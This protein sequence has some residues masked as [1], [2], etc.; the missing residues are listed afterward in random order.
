MSQKKKESKKTSSENLEKSISYE[1]SNK[2]EDKA[3]E[4]INFKD[5]F[6]QDTE[7]VY[8]TI[9]LSFCL[10][11]IIGFWG[12]S[13]YTIP[14]QIL[15]QRDPDVAEMKEAKEKEA[16]EK[17]KKDFDQKISDENKILK[18]DQTKNWNIN[19]EIK[20]FG[21]LTLNLNDKDAPK[22]VENFV[23]LSHR[24][25]YDNTIFHRIVKTP[26]FYIIQGGDK[27]SSN[28]KGGE[29]A[30]YLNN[31]ERGEIE[32]E[33]WLTKPEFGQSPNGEAIISNK[34]E[35]RNPSFYKNFNIQN[36]TVEYSKGLVLMAKKP[37]LNADSQFFITLDKTIL[38]AQ[39]T[40]FAQVNQDSFGTL[41]KIKNQINPKSGV[42]GIPDKEILIEKAQ[43]LNLK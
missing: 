14:Y 10:L 11:A 39:Y 30:F 32:D 18:F 12:F 5:S 16:K 35:F 28:G 22:T 25:Y 41:D 43:I 17:L 2:T 7:N 19:L 20:N 9:I 26:D 8:K 34:P 13:F 40:V 21:I 6:W 33:L 1:N 3:K 15:T 29:S 23:R 24:G 38:P 42:D 36:G 31:E 27:Q 4:N 37:G